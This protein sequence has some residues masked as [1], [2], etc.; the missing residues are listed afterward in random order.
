MS[1]TAEEGVGG[2]WSM[3]GKPE[4]LVD[5]FS[6]THGR[7]WEDQP[8]YIQ[9]INRDHSNL[10]KFGVHDAV[11]YR[12]RD[13]LREFADVAV[14]QIRARFSEGLGEGLVKP[15]DLSEEERKCLQAFFSDYSTD[16]Q[17]I[18]KHHPG[19]CQWVLEHPEFARWTKE[20]LS[21]PFWITGN[22]GMGKTVLSS[23]LVDVFE[24]EV[25]TRK[26]KGAV[27]YFFCS[28]Q[29]ENRRT[30]VS[31]LKAIIH[32]CLR[33]AP[34]MVR[35]H[36]VPTYKALGDQLYSSF[37]TLWDT[38]SA[39][40]SDSPLDRV[41]CIIDA[42]DEC[43][44][45][46][47]NQLIQQIGHYFERKRREGV[48]PYSQ[49]K[50]RLI[51]TSRPYDSIRIQLFPFM[52]IHLEAEGEEEAINCDIAVFIND[53]IEELS[54]LRGY[55]EFTKRQVHEALVSGA[56]GM[57][58]W[59]S[60]MIARLKVTPERKAELKLKELPRGVDGIYNRVLQE[61]PEG[62]DEEVSN[63]LKWVLFAFRPLNLVELGAAC[64]L[65]AESGSAIPVTL[66]SIKNE[67]RLCGPIL[68]IHNDSSVH[69]VHQTAKEFLR[70]AGST[71]I[72]I[73]R[74]LISECTAHL[75]IALACTTYLSLRELER[76]PVYG[77]HLDA[78]NED[79]QS[80]LRKLPLLEYAATHWYYHVRMEGE[81]STELWNCV[82]ESLC[83]DRKMN[84]SFQVHQFSK[85]EFFPSRQS[86]L[87][88]LVRA[89]LAAYIARFTESR[90]NGLD[91]KD[92][93]GD[94]PLMLAARSGDREV[95][96]LLIEKGADIEAEASDGGTVLYETAK[97]GAV[98]MVALLLEKS[99]N[100][101][102]KT[103]Y[104]RTPLLD[105]AAAGHAVVARLLLGNGADASVKEFEGGTSLHLAVKGRHIAMTRLLLEKGAD[106]TAEDNEGHTPLH[107]ALQN[108][109]E[110]LANLLLGKG[111]D[112]S[113][114]DRSGW[115]VGLLH[116][117][118]RS[119][120][121][122]ITRLL[123]S[124]GA[125]AAAKDNR[126]HTA[127][128][129]A[130]QNRH[131][132]LATLLLGSGA[133]INAEDNHG[134]TALHLAAHGGHEA[135]T[136]LLLKSGADIDAKNDEGYTALRLAVQNG[137][138]AVV[139]LLLNEGAPLDAI[140]H[141]GWT[142]LHQALWCG[143]ETVALLLL[144]KGARISIQDGDGNTALHLAARRG[145]QKSTSSLLD[146]G[147]DISG[148]NNNWETALHLASQEGHETVVRL[149][150]SRDAT[151]SARDGI[152]ET[153]LHWAAWN[154]HEGV[155]GLLLEN[156]TDISIENG[157][158]ETALHLAS[159]EGHEAVVCLLLSK[160]AM[161]SK[162]NRDGETALHW[163]SWGGREGVVGL[164][165]DHKADMSVENGD[166]ETALDLAYNRK[167]EAVI[168]LLFR[169]ADTKL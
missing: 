5:S 60:L 125:S 92:F 69:L 81:K 152:G 73:P 104:G 56:D 157:A 38:F 45:D 59:V 62:M 166:G 159:I 30:A 44:E 88:I 129:L 53:E 146:K 115:A 40:V 128:H 33:L 7:S 42:L 8:Q 79:Y 137:H 151:S 70:R 97:R 63:I 74:F 168:R 122:A 84:L 47:R 103:N 1:P 140:D 95:V 51:I 25:S 117:A 144:D 123:L 120:H 87:H 32:Q 121:E 61:I 37:A 105:A 94:T 67:I 142:A 68:K 17:K 155:V 161:T 75:D 31:L 2:K 132:V 54:K 114:K 169:A 106:V 43:K 77:T 76:G 23:F 36:V 98:E 49:N 150:L 163:A 89:R 39:I 27:V 66:E 85:K 108:G 149:L 167:H 99:A 34:V 165:L 9:A 29:D 15:P 52:V 78:S 18:P 48:Q 141:D 107:L 13:Q 57:F 21:T 65:S 58:L 136:S 109:H 147:A 164:L 50:L 102:A 111:A 131:E 135:M 6:A 133:D 46:S 116:L 28:D 19:T 22:P 41:Y 100:A 35:K 86:S 82:Y 139:S 93:L 91:G 113:V 90:G 55:S 126:G 124:V 153:A 127:L 160:G 83:D 24:T 101:N 72:R 158:G 118:V 26:S 4:I 12:V 16:R 64:G 145:R 143:H 14:N 20:E 134:Q 138:R 11:Y 119:K 71:N 10:V 154:G 130:V 162:R 3:K 80:L 148:E 112:I 110:V 156:G 96:R